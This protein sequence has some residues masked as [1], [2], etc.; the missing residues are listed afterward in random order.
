MRLR[1]YRRLRMTTN[2]KYSLKHHP[3]CKQEHNNLTFTMGPIK[4][5]T[6]LGIIR[7]TSLKG[8]MTANVE[9][10]IKKQGE[11][12]IAYCGGIPWP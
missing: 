1:I 3:Q 4:S 12:P 7:T 6:N 2:K 8:N 9:E 10:N 5:A 11:A